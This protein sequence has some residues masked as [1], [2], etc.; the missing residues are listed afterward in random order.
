MKLVT[1]TCKKDAHAI[2]LQAESISKFIDPCEHL[3]II[4]DDQLDYPYWN[5][6][7]SPYYIDHKLTIKSYNQYNIRCHSGWER[8]Q[9]YKLLAAMECDGKYLVLDSKNF[10]IKSTLL[11]EFEN[12]QASNAIVDLSFNPNVFPNA[13]LSLNYANYFNKEVLLEHFKTCT[14]YVVDTSYIDKNNLVKQVRWF[15]LNDDNITTHGAKKS[16]FIFYNYMASD[17][18][19]KYKKHHIYGARLWLNFTEEFGDVDTFIEICKNDDNCRFAGIHRA[20]ESITTLEEKNKILKWIRSIGL[21]A[22][23]WKEHFDVNV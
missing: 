15:S 12:F 22:S 1:V 9:C 2:R 3:I 23:P 20:V 21:K 19:Y 13:Y 5:D 8:Q 11:S 7:L 18:I 10:F 4:E 16:E 14:P 6:L 17:L